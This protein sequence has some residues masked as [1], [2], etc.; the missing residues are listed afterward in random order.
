VQQPDFPGTAR[1]DATVLT[2][3]SFGLSFV[4]TGRDLGFN[5]T[6]D[7]YAV[8]VLSGSANWTPISALPAT[9]R[10][11]STP[12]GEQTTLLFGGQDA[13]GGLTELWEY[14]PGSDTW[15]QRA[16]LPDSGRSACA[17]FY[18]SDFAY[19]VGGILNDG[20]ASKEVWKYDYLLDSWS[21][22]PDFPGT[23][24]HRAMYCD[25]GIIAG[26]ADSLFNPLDDVWR[27]D[28]QTETWSPLAPLPLPLYGAPAVSAFPNMILAGG[29][30]TGGQYRAD[31]WRYNI[32]TDTW[33]SYLSPIPT[34][35]KGLA[36]ILTTGSIPVLQVG[37]GIDST[38]TRYDDWWWQD[39]TLGVS[40]SALV[41]WEVFPIPADQEISIRFASGTYQGQVQLFDQLGRIVLEYSTNSRETNISLRGIPNGVYA[42]IYINENGERFAQK[43]IVQR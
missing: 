29:V 12:L 17:G 32:Q 4:G 13:N 33:V 25:A 10:Q 37:L 28:F 43:L 42:L 24:R 27:F 9:P 38:N 3:A 6:N 1:D 7:W 5:L 2:R 22:L 39:H 18:N 26:G 15:F 31:I 41:D 35:R 23:A 21:Q 36:L 40:S 19:V 11:Y 30:T 14:G 16:S 34:A 8:E 20:S